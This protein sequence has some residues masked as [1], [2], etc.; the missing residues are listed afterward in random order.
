MIVPIAKAAAE[1]HASARIAQRNVAN[2]IEIWKIRPIKMK[3]H[4]N[5]D[6]RLYQK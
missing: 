4:T 2:R 6:Y 1:P 3:M 5:L